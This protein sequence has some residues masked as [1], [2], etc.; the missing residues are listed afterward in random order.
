[1]LWVNSGYSSKIISK[2]DMDQYKKDPTHPLIINKNPPP[3][4][5]NDTAR[6]FFSINL[7][8]HRLD[9]ERAR[10]ETILYEECTGRK[11]VKKRERI[12]DFK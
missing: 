5:T 4:P 12:R 11:V 7:Q 3:P 10:L 6:K 1:M 2:F 8:I 9:T